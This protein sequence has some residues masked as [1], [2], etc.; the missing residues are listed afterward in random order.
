MSAQATH[1]PLRRQ[2]GPFRAYYKANARHVTALKKTLELFTIEE[3]LDILGSVD[4]LRVSMGRNYTLIGRI[5]T[6]RMVNGRV[7]IRETNPPPLEARNAL[8]AF[9]GVYDLYFYKQGDGFRV[10]NQGAHTLLQAAEQTWHDWVV[11]WLAARGRVRP[12]WAFNPLPG[13]ARVNVQRAM[14][15][16]PAPLLSVPPP[17]RHAAGHPLAIPATPQRRV[18]AYPL[19]VPATP[20]RR[21]ASPT[22]RQSSPLRGTRRRRSIIEISSDSDSDDVETQPPRKKMRFLG[23]IDLTNE[24]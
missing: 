24:D 5:S 22:S 6:H 10:R 1:P 23:T 16:A 18:A 7:Q 15:P 11:P 3:I 21:I 17:H 4:N 13:F 2:I 20:R 19:A 12:Q 9:L 8:E 14:P